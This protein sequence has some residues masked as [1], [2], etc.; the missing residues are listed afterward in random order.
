MN[1]QIKNIQLYETSIN[2]NHIQRIILNQFAHVSVHLTFFFNNSIW[3]LASFCHLGLLMYNIALLCTKVRISKA[4]VI[5]GHFV[6]SLKE[7]SRLYT[8]GMKERHSL[9]K[10]VV[11]ILLLSL[12]NFVLKQK[13]HVGH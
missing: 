10:N 13:E 11:S 9:V 4:I 6:N 7:R 8:I 5:L 3:G 1:I 2:L 12:L